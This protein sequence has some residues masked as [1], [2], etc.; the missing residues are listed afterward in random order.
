MA[1]R[2]ALTGPTARDRSRGHEY[3]SGC[4]RIEAL[5]N[6]TFR[7]GRGARRSAPGCAI[8]ASHLHRSVDFFRSQ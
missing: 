8:V 3:C 7:M 1:P 2:E 6:G 4:R 5:T